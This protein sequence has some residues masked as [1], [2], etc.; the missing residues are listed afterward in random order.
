MPLVADSSPQFVQELSAADACHDGFASALAHFVEAY[1]RIPDLPQEEGSLLSNIEPILPKSAEVMGSYATQASRA[2][3][4]E[5]AITDEQRQ[6]LAYFLLPEGRSLLDLFDGYVEAG[7]EID[8]LLRKRADA[9][10]VVA[11]DRSRAAAL[12][13]SAIGILGQLRAALAGELRADPKRAASVDQQMFAYVD[14]LQESRAKGGP[15]AAPPPA[16]PAAPAS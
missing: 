4:R 9:A 11:K 12:R 10:T 2:Q 6:A 7:G 14:R 15:T 3:E 5:Q 8:S 1:E 16:P 13:G